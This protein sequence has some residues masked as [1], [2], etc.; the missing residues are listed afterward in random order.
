MEIKAFPGGRGIS[1]LHTGNK[2][3]SKN[4]KTEAKAKE[5]SSV[6]KDSI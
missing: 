1:K 6:R 2:S 5:G 3:V 4:E